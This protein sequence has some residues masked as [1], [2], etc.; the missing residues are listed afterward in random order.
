ML[1]VISVAGSASLYFQ[2]QRALLAGCAVG[3]GLWLFYILF[4][5]IFDDINLITLQ[6]SKVLILPYYIWSLSIFVLVTTK[7]GGAINSKVHSLLAT[8][9]LGSAVV[10]AI[11]LSVFL[12]KQLTDTPKAF[13]V[14]QVDFLLSG[15]YRRALDYI[16]ED[17][18]RLYKWIKKN[19]LENDVILHPP[20]MVYIRPIAQRS[21]VV[22]NHLLSFNIK[23]M[24]AWMERSDMLEGFCKMSILDLK[25]IARK[26]NASWIIIRRS[27]ARVGGEKV[28]FRN[29]SWI[30]VR[31]DV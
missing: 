1:G 20:D 28:S 22:Q 30:V 11:T 8:V 7:L 24:K 18:R 10:M 23:G 13:V 26:Y 12:N 31:S 27:C 5:Q 6:G 25:A 14:R 15:N 29:A 19:T 2:G 9:I 16:E 17:E 21:S 4:I 3:L